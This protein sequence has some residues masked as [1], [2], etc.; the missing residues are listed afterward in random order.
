MHVKG[1]QIHCYLPLSDAECQRATQQGEPDGIVD[2]G[3]RT[4]LAS[5]LH[6]D[7]QFVIS[8]QDA[9]VTFSQGQEMMD[10]DHMDDYCSSTVP[11]P[12][13]EALQEIRTG[14][15]RHGLA[16]SIESESSLLGSG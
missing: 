8:L 3:T 16:K 5:F 11:N 13:S 2:M 15:D 9:W 6:M 14:I 4:F 1:S 10:R 12:K 7:G